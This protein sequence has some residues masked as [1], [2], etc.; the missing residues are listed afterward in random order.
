[1]SF[2][3]DK[4]K[5]KYRIKAPID[6]STNDFQREP[7]GAFADN[8]IYDDFGKYSLLLRN[9]AKSCAGYR[10]SYEQ[11]YECQRCRGSI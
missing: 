10:K 5:G 3:I 2:L 9:Y 6:I 8:D 7:N 4:F 1:M 11:A